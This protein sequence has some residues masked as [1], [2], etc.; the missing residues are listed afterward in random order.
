ME[1]TRLGLL[2]SVIWTVFCLGACGFDETPTSAACVPGM[3]VECP[4]RNG[5]IGAQICS[6][7]GTYGTCD[8]ILPAGTSGSD[9]NSSGNPDAG[10]SSSGTSGG[11]AGMSG[12]DA[13]S[14]AGAGNGAAGNGAAGSIAAGTSGGAGTSVGGTGGVS[15][16]GGSGQAGSMATACTPGSFSCAFTGGVHVVTRCNT[17]GTAFDPDHACSGNE[18]C[19]DGACHCIAKRVYC[20]DNE[21]RECDA[22]GNE[23]KV[24]QTCTDGQV[25]NASMRKCQSLCTPDDCSCQGSGEPCCTA[26]G[27]CGCA[28]FL[29]LACMPQNGDAQQCTC[30]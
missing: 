10:S 25:C 4:C 20:Q 24:L 22:M 19:R 29:G 6:T 27:L 3:R 1:G 11:A 28:G 26:A 5:R 2:S 14:S 8:C 7:E 21:L 9:A 15:G 30:G 13:G 12:G 23:S 18:T 16:F 17:G